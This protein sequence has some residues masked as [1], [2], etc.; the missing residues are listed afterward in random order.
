MRYLIFPVILVLFLKAEAQQDFTLIKQ[1]TCNCT[2]VSVDQLGNE[3]YQGPRFVQR[4]NA[5]GG[6]KFRNSE[7]Q[8]GSY[9]SI[10]LTDPLRPFIHFST[11]GKI[12]FWDNTLSVQGSPIDLFEKGY[13]QIEL[14]CGSRG[15]AFW[16]WDARQSELIRVD[17]SFQRLTSTGNLGVLL[18][19]SVLPVQLMERGAYLYVRT[20][21]HRLLVFDIYGTFKKQVQLGAISDMH[22]EHDR[23]FLFADKEVQFMNANSAEIT[24]LTL[25][26]G[27]ARF[28]AARGMLYAVK[29]GVVYV[30]RIPETARN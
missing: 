9:E 1:E 4:V 10:D 29:E 7:L 15:D 23:I 19:F 21:D 22:V 6:G 11:S 3:Y 27:G 28:F 26:I 2:H 13:D 18:G 17:R 24:S 12:V 16:M 30:Y 8:W 25:P 14:V 5:V 20:S